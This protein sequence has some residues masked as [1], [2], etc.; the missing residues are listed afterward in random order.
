PIPS[1]E[2]FPGLREVQGVTP[3]DRVI[4]SGLVVARPGTKVLPREMR[5][6]DVA[7]L[8]PAS[9]EQQPTTQHA[10]TVGQGPSRSNNG[11]AAAGGGN[12]VTGG[13]GAGTN[14]ATGGGAGGVGSG[15]GR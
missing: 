5:I 4:V 8:P 15:G 2:I 9:P 1:G 10:P 11:P 14:G 7:K 3:A 13:G 6:E 12:G